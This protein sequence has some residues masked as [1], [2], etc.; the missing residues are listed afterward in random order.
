MISFLKYQFPAVLW[1]ACIYIA[2][3]I[4]SSRLSWYFL[5][6]VDK[7]IHFGIC[8][9]LGR[10]VYG[11]L[12]RKIS[13]PDFSY[14]KVFIMLSIVIGYGVLDELHQ[15]GTPG[16]T[17]DIYDLLA[18]AGGGICAGLVIAF[19]GRRAGSTGGK[20]PRLSTEEIEP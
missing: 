10:L 20:A 2:S 11:G 14:K 17:M 4:P 18:D 6:R 9:I 3:S 7:Y 1:A 13:S 16:R 15:A 5:H 8:F 19:F 12:C